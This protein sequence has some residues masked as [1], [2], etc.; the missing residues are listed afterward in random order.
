MP[1]KDESPGTEHHR[2]SR[3]LVRGETGR[4]PGP[5]DGAGVDRGM[6][7]VAQP[8]VGPDAQL[9]DSLTPDVPTSSDEMTAALDRCIEERIARRNGGGRRSPV[10][11]RR[12][13]RA[14]FRRR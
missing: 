5:D 13:E 11:Y 9:R 7:A 14:W 4:T 1:R 12:P 10:R 8:E 6:G 3:R 2:S